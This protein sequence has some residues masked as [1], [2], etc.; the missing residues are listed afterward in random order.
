MSLDRVKGVV[1]SM[2]ESYQETLD[3]MQERPDWLNTHDFRSGLWIGKRDRLEDKIKDLKYVMWWLE[4]P[5][6]ERV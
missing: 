4:H 5:N 1:Y 6:G 3:M 2:I